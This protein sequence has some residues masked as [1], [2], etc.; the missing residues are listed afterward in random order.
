MSNPMKLDD[1]IRLNVLDALMKKNSVVPNIRQVKRHC[2][3]HKA[4]IKS[5]IDF[6][7]KEG[8]IEGFGPR[9]N[10]KK[11]GYKLEAIEMLQID[12]AEKELFNK[13]LQAV[14][15]DPHI[16]RLSAIIGSGNWN[17]MVRH[18][19]SDVESFHDNSQKNYFEKI[20]GIYDL[21][22]DRLIFFS[23]EPFYKSVSRTK[24]LIDVIKKEK[25]ID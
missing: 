22:Q 5:S 19:Y 25:G 24:S 1:E 16:Y 2:G 11:F 18:F 7:S 20:K 10:F 3:Y 12:F 14:N 9:I 17:L 6:L 4:T 23:T 13:F 15:K 8:L 21:I